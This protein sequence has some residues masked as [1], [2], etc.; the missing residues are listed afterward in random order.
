MHRTCAKSADASC[1]R[2]PPHH[3]LSMQSIAG[4][5][6]S[7]QHR[8][9][10][11]W[12][13]SAPGAVSVDWAASERCPAMRVSTH[14]ACWELRADGKLSG[15]QFKDVA[16]MIIGKA[17]C[18]AALSPEADDAHRR[19]EVL[20]H[21]L[22]WLPKNC[23]PEET[24]VQ[25]M[26]KLYSSWQTEAFYDAHHELSLNHCEGKDEMIAKHLAYSRRALVERYRARVAMHR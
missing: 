5:Y 22:P 18:I 6:F 26:R 24:T 10:Y 2:R 15:Q 14:V 1:L 9:N 17:L 7:F 23:P 21:L 13:V 11:H 3:T 8:G 4:A 16:D 12:S 19:S 20:S 25:W